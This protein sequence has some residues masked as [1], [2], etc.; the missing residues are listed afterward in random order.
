[1]GTC[2]AIAYIKNARFVPAELKEHWPEAHRGLITGAADRSGVR[3]LAELSHP[4][5]EAGVYDA[6]T[7]TALV[8][9]NFTYQPIDALQVRLPL[10]RKPQRLQSVEHGPIEFTVEPPS[11]RNEACVVKF[12][13]PLG[14]TDIVLADG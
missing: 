2:P 5:V 8:L 1:V 13:V 4:V 10:P 11:G 3:R 14:L 9:A 7:G 12:S 6:P